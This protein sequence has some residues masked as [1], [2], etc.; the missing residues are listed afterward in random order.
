MD[1]QA[2][3]KQDL[4]GKTI[5]EKLTYGTSVTNAMGTANPG[6]EPPA[7]APAIGAVAS[8]G[9]LFQ[10]LIAKQEVAAMANEK[11]KQAK[12]KKDEAAAIAEST[13]AAQHNAEEEYD[14]EFTALGRGVDDVAKGD[15]A[16]IDK[17][18]MESFFPGKAA[19]IGQLAQ[20]QNF[21]L[22]HSDNEYELDAQWDK[23]K[24]ASSYILEKAIDNPTGWTYAGTSTKSSFTLTGLPVGMKTWARCA[25]VGSA[26]QGPWSDPAVKGV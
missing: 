24:G 13:S 22:T 12:L 26:G 16:I 14:K 17:A 6:D 11:L 25:A 23:V 1:K 4:F 20:V 3:V 15:K 8:G 21:S 2:K 18:G 7:P 19:P 9:T 5:S 10:S